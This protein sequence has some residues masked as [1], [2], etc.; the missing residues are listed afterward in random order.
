MSGWRMHRECEPCNQE[1]IE[2]LETSHRKALAQ[3]VR[4]YVGEICSHVRTRRSSDQML[5]VQSNHLN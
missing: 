1:R 2:E 4:V 3:L 5:L